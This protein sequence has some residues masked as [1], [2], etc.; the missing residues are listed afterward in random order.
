MIAFTVVA[1]APALA[2]QNEAILSWDE[3]RAKGGARNRDFDCTSDDGSHSLVVS[4]TVDQAIPQ[5]L[6]V[7]ATLGVSTIMP[8]HGPG[9]C[10]GPVMPEWWQFQGCRLGSLYGAMNFHGA[11]YATGTGCVDPWW[12]RLAAARCQ[13]TYP[14]NPQ[15]PYGSGDDYARL[16]VVGDVVSPVSVA[17]GHEYYAFALDLDHV[18][19]VGEGACAGCCSPVWIGI[20]YMRLA[21]PE[22]VGDFWLS[23]NNDGTVSWQGGGSPCGPTPAARRTWGQLKGMYR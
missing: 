18:H 2:Q 5:L 14:Y 13:Y 17:P 10:D 8:C 23:P 22:G 6:G 12:P 1:V 21:Q 20:G 19:T 4:F 7:V 16:D 11:P 9:P 15:Q 3:C